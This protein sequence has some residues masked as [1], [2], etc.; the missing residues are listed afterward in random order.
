VIVVDSSVLI[1]FLR[2]H[3]SPAITRFQELEQEEVPY[4]LPAFCYQEVLQGAKDEREWRLL[5]EYLGS[6]ELLLPQ[7]LLDTHFNAARIFFDCRRKGLTI[8]SSVD[9]FLAQLA[10]LCQIPQAV[11]FRVLRP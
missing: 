10:L 11:D 2:G 8:R 3:N 4:L 5:R 1:G 6:Q 7:D 9:C